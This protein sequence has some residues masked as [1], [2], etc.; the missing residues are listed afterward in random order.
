MMNSCIISSLNH[1]VKKNCRYEQRRIFTM[2]KACRRA[3]IRTAFQLCKGRMSESSGFQL[4]TRK[5]P[6]YV[7][8]VIIEDLHEYLRGRREDETERAVARPYNAPCSRCVIGEGLDTGNQARQHSLVLNSAP[9]ISCQFVLAVFRI[10]HDRRWKAGW[11][12]RIINVVFIPISFQI[13]DGYSCLPAFRYPEGRTCRNEKERKENNNEF[14]CFSHIHDI[15]SCVERTM[16]PL[17]YM[18]HYPPEKR[19]PSLHIRTLPNKIEKQSFHTTFT[20]SS[21]NDPEGQAG[22]LSSAN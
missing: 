11:G 15:S 20:Q 3:G 19:V 4:L 22:L 5:H 6:I 9:R 13:E 16:T 8:C 1:Q 18:Q 21:K 14:V 10:E 7:N 17:P 12:C 2:L